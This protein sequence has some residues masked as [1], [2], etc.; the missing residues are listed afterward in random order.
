MYEKLIQ[1]T[2]EEFDMR[3]IMTC[4]LMI[5]IMFPVAANFIQNADCTNLSPFN[6][7][8]NWEVRTQKTDG[9]K[10]APGV[11]TLDAVA[12]ASEVFLI[13]R[14]L[15]LT[16]G[17]KYR[18]QYSVKG[19]GTYRTYVEYS[20]G[21]KMTAIGAVWQ[22]ASAD[23][24]ERF[25]DISLAPD[26]SQVKLVFH[27]RGKIELRGISLVMVAPATGNKLNSGDSNIDPVNA[28][29]PAPE[30]GENLMMLNVPVK[31]NGKSKAFKN[32]DGTAGVTVK[33]VSNYIPG[34]VASGLKVEPGKSYELEYQVKGEGK[35]SNTTGIMHFFDVR[36]DLKDGSELLRSTWDDVMSH[37]FIPK[38]FVF[39]VPEKHGGII[40]IAM[41][42]TEGSEV[43]F[44]LGSLKEKIIVPAENMRLVI[45]SP[46]YHNGIFE[47]KPVSEV[48]GF[49]EVK[50][51]G[52]KAEFKVLRDGKV[53]GEQSG[54]VVNGK[55]EF[56]FDPAMF[57]TGETRIECRIIDAAGKE[58]KQLNQ[59]ITRYPRSK[60]NEVVIGQDKQFYVN[61]RLFFP[62]VQYGMR[63]DE[64]RHTD[65]TDIDTVRYLSRGGSNVF[66]FTPQ[67]EK[68]ALRLLD[69]LVENNSMAMFHVGFWRGQA[70]MENTEKWGHGVCNILTP[71]VVNHPGF[72][73]FYFAD[74]PRWNG[75][76]A[77]NLQMSGEV[78]RKITPYHP[79]HIVA[80]PRGSVEDHLPYAATAD[81]YGIDIYPV[82]KGSHSN[83]DDKTLTSVGKYTQRAA[84]M[85][86]HR[87]PVLMTLQAFAWGE[88]SKRER[89]YPTLA[90]SRFMA[91]DAFLNGADHVAYYALRH[92]VS[93]EFVD[94]INAV[95]LELNRMS[96]LLASGK[97]I[98]DQEENGI[99]YRVIEFD[100]K[101]YMIALNTKPENRKAVIKAG[102][103]SGKVDVLEEKRQVVV[104]D[105]NIAEEFPP[106][107]V[108]VYAEAPLPPPVG[109]L[110]A[111]PAKNPWVEYSRQRQSIVFYQGN[112]SWIWD[113]TV[114][115]KIKS[116]VYLSRQFELKKPVK[117]IRLLA[118][119]DN[120]AQI[121]LN[122]KEIGKVD[123]WVIMTEFNLTEVA[124]PGRNLL[125][126]FAA[127]GA[128]PPCAFLADI[129]IQYQ[130]GSTEKIVT[131]GS[132]LC[133]AVRIKDWMN[134]EV[135]EKQFKKVDF[136]VPYGGGRWGK[137]VQVK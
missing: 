10:V 104:T 129:D 15:P 97:V 7:P 22:N 33:Y 4:L 79:T 14:N 69:L 13:Q 21:K 3:F 103:K 130:D 85:V 123:D 71:K 54:K 106:F 89:I 53:L 38:K 44:L 70:T 9:F 8:V 76:P 116:E 110:P 6:L 66:I 17:K 133:S 80:A 98:A 87:K 64:L 102:F 136:V 49:A 82:P 83:L 67:S 2:G 86:E 118:S 46:A 52:E 95:T 77:I 61:G 34:A 113:N 84:A 65:Q 117:T 50:T 109:K 62:I 12:G 127:D 63:P 75:V 32:A 42:V 124:K 137:K 101:R 94:E 43:T 105:G 30:A 131:D 74:E 96:R 122:G 35:A 24:Q 23:W 99:H 59:V 25:L 28:K 1:K 11:I 47:T 68:E 58:V 134:P 26:P 78:L 72:F 40:D 107:G 45:T 51:G 16:A 60:G 31:L 100:N 121:W 120:M 128:N 90:E 92:V 115:N 132:W 125:S 135:V 20:A 112:A 91:Y 36:I 39:K 56:S 5:S 88:L 27:V 93:P 114:A 81:Y 55:A 41:G 48:A 111:G 126:V 57:R 108:R 19:Q 29:S 18:L 37:G 73:G 119:A